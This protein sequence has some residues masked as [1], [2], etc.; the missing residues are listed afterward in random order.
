MNNDAELIDPPPIPFG[1]VT[2][3]EKQ[4]AAQILGKEPVRNPVSPETQ[5]A[6]TAR[7][8]AK[9]TVYARALSDVI[10]PGDVVLD[11]GSGPYQLVAPKVTAL[12]ATYVPHDKYHGINPDALRQQYD[13][14]MA[15]N[16]LNVQ[17]KFR[18]AKARYQQALDELVAAVRPGGTLVVNMPGGSGTPK[19]KWMTPARLQQD[20][21]RRFPSVVRHG[22]VI[23][24]STGKPRQQNPPAGIVVPE[25]I[26]AAAR[27]GLKFHAEGLGGDGLVAETVREAREMARGQ[28]T[29]DKL[30]RANAWAKRHAVDL[31]ARQNSDPSNPRWPGAGAV[32]HLLWGIN[33]ASPDQARN[34]FER[35]AGAVKP[36][37]RN[38]KEVGKTVFTPLAQQAVKLGDFYRAGNDVVFAESLEELRGKLRAL[39]EAVTLEG[40]GPNSNY[41]KAV[42]VFLEWLNDPVKNTPPSPIFALGNLKLP[43]WNF[44]TVPGVTCPGAGACLTRPDGKLGWCYS[45][46]SWRY[47]TPFFRQLQNTLLI[48][49][50]QHADSPQHSHILREM[51]LKLK[52]GESVRLYVDGD[53]DSV[54][55]IDFWM[56][57]IRRFP[58]VQFYG[59]SKSWPQFIAWHKQHGGDW[60]ANYVL[61]LSSGTKLERVGGKVYE[62]AVREMQSLRNPQTGLPLVRGRFVAVPASVK[63]PGQKDKDFKAKFN[64]YRKSVRESA[65]QLFNRDD[66]F[67]CPGYCGE[68]L[69]AGKHACGSRKMQDKMIVIGIH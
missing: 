48:R 43:F 51:E 3:E 12:G 46:S 56:R 59:Y 64:A 41:R 21:Q 36:M 68:C 7:P 60:P 13:V 10:R 55:T 19:A 28:I 49:M 30:V 38:P 39:D 34:W 11:Y 14:V 45:F 9:T 24:A 63:A 22:E 17:A 8:W 31:Q 27:R 25:F 57:A 50:E 42:K 52:P 47:V 69:G 58:K 40:K 20:L 26:R 23:V 66:V 61:N 44:S 4:E 2:L 18:D 5:A 29:A 15:S 65:M 35:K 62:D 33:P 32:A 1:D 54:A 16:V 37:R 6:R 67:V 53:M